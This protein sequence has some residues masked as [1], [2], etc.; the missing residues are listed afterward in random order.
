MGKTERE[1]EREKVTHEKINMHHNKLRKVLTQ[2]VVTSSTIQ[3]T[4]SSKCLIVGYL[5]HSLNHLASNIKN[6]TSHFLNLINCRLH[7]NNLVRK[8]A[9][10]HQ[11]CSLE[12][13]FYDKW[14][15]KNI[16]RNLP[17][18]KIRSRD[19]SRDFR[20]TIL[21]TTLFC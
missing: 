1:R 18:N 19:I 20:S 6:M 14:E 4:R 13:E 16:P 3:N 15:K 2:P 10:S 5:D 12:N 21:H 9:I 17:S 11:W 8:N 7:P